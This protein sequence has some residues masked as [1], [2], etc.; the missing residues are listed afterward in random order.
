MS[1]ISPMVI[2][3]DDEDLSVAISTRIRF[4][5]MFDKN[6]SAVGDSINRCVRDFWRIQSG[7]RWKS[8]RYLI[9]GQVNFL[10]YLDHNDRALFSR[11]TTLREKHLQD[12]IWLRHLCGETLGPV[13]VDGCL[14]RLLQD[15]GILQEYCMLFIHHSFHETALRILEEFASSNPVCL[16]PSYDQLPDETPETLAI[17]RKMQLIINDHLQFLPWNMGK[18]RFWSK[19]GRVTLLDFFSVHDSDVSG[20]MRARGI[21]WIPGPLVE[22]ILCKAFFGLDL[23]S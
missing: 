6:S 16:M 3:T 10:D 8:I 17:G 23:F 2:A 22:R 7:Q 21:S 19:T 15:I 11:H 1:T 18:C 12:L 4:A 14:H 5:K 9:T 13:E 20:A